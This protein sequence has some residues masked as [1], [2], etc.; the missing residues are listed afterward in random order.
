MREFDPFNRNLHI[1]HPE[2]H[3]LPQLDI[4]DH[5]THTPVEELAAT[6]FQM[7]GEFVF[8]HQIEFGARRRW[9]RVDT[10]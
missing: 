6:D 10:Q 5:S 1:P 2:A 3:R 8:G 4:G 9:L 7:A